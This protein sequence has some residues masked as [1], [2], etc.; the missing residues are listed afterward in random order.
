MGLSISGSPRTFTSST[1][2][3]L[4]EVTLLSG[5]TGNLPISIGHVFKPGDL[6]DTEYLQD[7]QLDIKNR[8][9][10]SSVKFAIISGNVNFTTQTFLLPLTKGTGASGANVSI[11]DLKNTSITA[12]IST[13]TFG[14]ASWSGTDWDTPFITWVTGPKM[15]SW[16][17]RKQ[18]GTDPHLVAWLE[19]RMWSTGEVEILPWIENG[20]LTV[21]NPTNKPSTYSFSLNGV[22]RFN[23]SLP[24]QHH[25]RMPLVTGSVL[26]YWLSGDKT[27]TPKYDNS[28]LAETGYVQAY[29]S[30]VTQV[31]AVPLPTLGGV[32]STF[33][34]Y[35]QTTG[36]NSNHSTSM[37]MGG[38]HPSI[39]LQ[40]GWEAV[41]LT[42]G[43]TLAHE[44]MIRE[45]YRFGQYHIHY[46]DSRLPCLNLSSELI[47]RGY[48]NCLNSNIVGRVILNRE[49]D[50]LLRKMLLF[51]TLS[52]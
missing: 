42:A 12:S 34:P 25:T 2:G 33:V 40:P 38:G 48:K 22:E 44:Q 41:A 49:V 32:P 30:D 46:R 24:V 3:I 18:V 23:A 15:S 28:Y 50:T 10:D 19:I 20:Y 11:S 52:L 5:T 14:S 13:T 36:S 7:L 6:L 35:S 17:Y 45:S 37:G 39:G 43:G 27:T 47:C 29:W 1:L 16:I 31:S 26:S 21:A 9:P 51:K 4:P 8:W